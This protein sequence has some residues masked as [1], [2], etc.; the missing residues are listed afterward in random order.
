MLSE[1]MTAG[2]IKTTNEKK[3]QLA[4]ESLTYNFKKEEQFFELFGGYFSQIGIDPVTK[5]AVLKTV[6]TEES[7]SAQGQPPEERKESNPI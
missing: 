6:Q 4:R 2:G 7:K 5:Q 1:E 3:Q